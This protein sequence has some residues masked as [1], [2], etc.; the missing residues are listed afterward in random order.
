MK[1]LLPALLVGWSILCAT[2]AAVALPDIRAGFSEQQHYFVWLRDPEKLT[3]SDEDIQA[4]LVLRSMAKRGILKDNFLDKLKSEGSLGGLYV[5]HLEVHGSFYWV[6]VFCVVLFW[7]IP[8]LF[9]CVLW[10]KRG[11]A[12]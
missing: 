7:G 2:L 1:N 9:I 6:Y 4:R 11:E 8:S 10:K 3:G 5:E 12:P